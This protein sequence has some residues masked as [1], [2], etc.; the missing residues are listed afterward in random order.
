MSERNKLISRT[1][2]LIHRVRAKDT[3]GRWA[4]YFIYVLEPKEQLFLEAIKSKRMFDLEKYGKVLA[5]NY[6]HEPTERV[7]TFLMVEYGLKV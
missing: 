5:S 4:Y 3:T 2:H 7:K 6:G 1:L